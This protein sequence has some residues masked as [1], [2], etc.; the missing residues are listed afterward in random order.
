[1]AI[2][3]ETFFLVPG[4]LGTLQQQIQQMVAEGIVTGR[5]RPGDRLPSSR[6][7]ARA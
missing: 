3:A 4:A 5:F 7:L 6:K 1:M 2:S